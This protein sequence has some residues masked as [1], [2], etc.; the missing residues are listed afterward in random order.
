MRRERSNQ[1]MERTPK[2]F[3]VAHLILVSGERRPVAIVG[4][5]GFL[6]C[7]IAVLCGLAGYY[8]YRNAEAMCR[9]GAEAA[10]RMPRFLRWLTQS[11]FYL[12]PECASRYRSTGILHMVVGGIFFLVGV[13]MIIVSIFRFFT[14]R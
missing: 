3:G 5:V 11:N 12:S 8:E 7:G 1:A 10:E 6:L 2:A 9:R 4:F 14:A 13:G